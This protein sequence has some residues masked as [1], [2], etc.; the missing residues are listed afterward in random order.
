MNQNQSNIKPSSS[1]PRKRSVAAFVPMEPEIS[2]RFKYLGVTRPIKEL[3]KRIR[4]FKRPVNTRVQQLQRFAER[5]K[6]CKIALHATVWILEALTEGLTANFATHHLIG[7]A[8]SAE[9]V[10]AHG[11]VIKQGLSIYWR[12]RNKDGA[13]AT[14]LD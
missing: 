6:W 2:Q 10:L 4:S 14:V 12:T 1:R 13:S 8:F 7:V 3:F 5:V 9:M 11:I